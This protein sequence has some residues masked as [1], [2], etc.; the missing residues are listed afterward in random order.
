MGIKL[1]YT[2]FLSSY[3][4]WIY[5]R[6]FGPVFINIKLFLCFLSHFTSLKRASRSAELSSKMF[7]LCRIPS[8]YLECLFSSKRSLSIKRVNAANIGL[9]VPKT[10][11]VSTVAAHLPSSL[12]VTLQVFSPSIT[13]FKSPES[14]HIQAKSLLQNSL[15]ATDKKQPSANSYHFVTKELWQI[16]CPATRRSPEGILP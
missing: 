4:L 7:Y 16:S 10:A 11:I 15:M 3:L 13:Q 5:Y 2:N 1:K 14:H 12:S 8:R 6:Y 9:H